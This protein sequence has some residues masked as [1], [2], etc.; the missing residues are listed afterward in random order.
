MDTDV[1]TGAPSAPAAPPPGISKAVEQAVADQ[2]FS[3]FRKA[4]R[5]ERSGQPLESKPADSTPAKPVDQAA[6]TDAT[7][8][9]ASEPAKP[10]TEARFQE[11]LTER[12]TL[13]SENDR[14][15]REL[16]DARRPAAKSDV[17]RAESSPAAAA[18]IT[19]PAELASA[20]AFSA[21]HPTAS[22]ED[23]LDARADFRAEQR[24]TQRDQA[25][26]Q[27]AERTA[28]TQ[29]LTER[30]RQ[31]AGCIAEAT[32]ADPEFLTKIHKDVLDLKPFDQLQPGEQPTGYHC[33]A[34]EILD[35]IA[36][37]PLMRHFSDHP[38]DLHRI[39]KLQPRALLRE[40]GKLEASLA[41]IPV[42]APKH[43]TDAPAPPTTLGSRP[44]SD[45]DPSQSAVV[46]QDFSAFRRAE[47]Q[48]LL[49]GARR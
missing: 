35:S 1:T 28:R 4:E 31:Y 47:R 32:T 34:E 41:N 33:I 23:Y 10:K 26:Q 22:Y 12:S 6:S 19:Y 24:F 20:E 27:A 25:Q 29:A 46:K 13:R 7:P 44:T 49:A 37:A 40:M 30:D 8:K 9:P 45:V 36:A 16:D 17:P 42:V 3:A 38:E 21:K 11:L 14:L 18:T 2:N 5:A 48:K 39:A 15:R 43:V